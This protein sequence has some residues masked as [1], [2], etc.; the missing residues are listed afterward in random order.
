M[1]L[2]L[3][4]GDGDPLGDVESGGG[5]ELAGGVVG[6]ALVEPVKPAGGLD[7]AAAAG[8]VVHVGAAAVG[9]AEWPPAVG[10]A[11]CAS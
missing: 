2:P 10:C 1:L 7:L 8:G 11:V 6:L 5:V 3:G 4:L 9:A